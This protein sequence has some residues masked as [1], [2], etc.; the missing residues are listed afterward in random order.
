MS[1]YLI[2]RGYVGASM[3]PAVILG[4]V[5]ADALELTTKRHYLEN[6]E[7]SFIYFCIIHVFHLFFLHIYRTA[8]N[9]IMKPLSVSCSNF[10]YNIKITINSFA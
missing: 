5:R 1:Y 6:F 4:Q 3:D 10:N 8:I 7:I 9:Q 2:L